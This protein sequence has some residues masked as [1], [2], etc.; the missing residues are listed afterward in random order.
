MT[1]F[2]SINVKECL[3]CFMFPA[4]IR[5]TRFLKEPTSAL[6]C[7]NAVLLQSNHG[8]FSATHVVIFRMI[9]TRMQMEL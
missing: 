3:M 6:G 2:I 4:L 9:S 7:M 8:F 1:T 5:H